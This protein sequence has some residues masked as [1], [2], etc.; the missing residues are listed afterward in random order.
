[1]AYGLGALI[2]PGVAGAAMDRWNPQ[3]LLYFFILLFAGFLPATF[4][5]WGG[6]RFIQM[7]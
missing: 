1:M 5:R 3:G 7:P 6:R 4:I 2:G